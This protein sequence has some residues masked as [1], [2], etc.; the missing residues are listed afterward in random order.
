MPA[1]S[2]V[3]PAFNRAETIAVTLDSLVAQSFTD[4]EAIVV[5]DGSTDSTAAVVERY[6]VSD[7]RIRLLRQANAG[8]GAARNVGDRAEPGTLGLLPGRRRLGEP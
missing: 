2:V 3:V 7:A 6:A 8:V 1:V 5:D 4:W